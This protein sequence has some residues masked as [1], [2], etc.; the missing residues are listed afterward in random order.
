[1]LPVATT[2]TYPVNDPAV[3]KQRLADYEK[4]AAGAFAENTM[5]AIRA[6]VRVFA[7]WCREIG[8]SPELP[9]DPAT[10]ADF[11]DAMSARRKPATVSRY[12][13]S[14]NHT[15][16][17]AGLTEPGHSREVSLALRRMRR[18]NGT[19]QAQADALTRDKVD[20]ILKCLGDS[21]FDLRDAALVAV[22]YDT[23]AR[24]SELV[25]LDVEHIAMSD[26]GTGAAL[27]VR[28]KTDQEG[29]GDFRFVSADTM[30]RLAA[31]TEAASLTSGPLF[32]PLGNA[33]IG[34]RLDGGEVSRIFKRRSAQAC[35][36]G[37]K[38]SGHSAR[39]GAAQDA[40]AASLSLAE[41][42]Q[43]GGWRNPRMPARYGERLSV[44][45]SAS[46]K[47]AALQGR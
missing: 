26:D 10:I 25:S 16:R 46:A 12:I 31:W 13:A 41:I 4:A 22:A 23:L 34:E 1:M 7:G 29:K 33:A 32:I 8:A 43:A 19:R 15:H 35:L 44:R 14:L 40:H 17:A 28:S 5:R 18:A 36:L 6:D 42:M 24:R 38:P 11:I 2:I 3:I 45:R 37:F 39:I 21:L 30:A 47:L 27:I 9:A 20:R